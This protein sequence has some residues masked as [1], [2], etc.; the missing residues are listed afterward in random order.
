MLVLSASAPPFCPRPFRR[1]RS[2]PSHASVVPVG[3]Q[4]LRRL[5]FP[6][7]LVVARPTGVVWRASL[8]YEVR[9]E[10]RGEAQDCR[11]TAG[12]GG[13]G[14]TGEVEGGGGRGVIGSSV[15]KGDHDEG[16]HDEVGTF[17][18]S[19]SGERRL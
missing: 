17:L 11:R 2:S 18:Y 7:V 6:Q 8:F 1:P 14:M 13:T 10:S 19:A 15:E 5:T 9:R 3:H 12:G 4:C 16:A